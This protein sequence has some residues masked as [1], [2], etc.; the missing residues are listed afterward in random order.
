MVL[1]TSLARALAGLYWYYVYTPKEVDIAKLA[2]HVDSL[3]AQNQ[4]AKAELAKGSIEQIREEVRILRGNLDL[5]RTLVPTANEVPSL[6][7][8]VSSA[9]RRAHLDVG[10]IDPSPVIEGELF[11]TYR[12]RMPMNGAY[13]D[14]AQMLTNI[15]SLNRIVTA[16]NLQLVMPAGNLVSPP[17]KQLLGMT[18]DIQAY[19]IR[20]VARAKPPAPPGAPSDGK[21]PA[22]KAPG[23]GE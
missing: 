16:Y 6:I 2:T 11:D 22:G 5:M 18:F 14:I 19:V 4:R 20:T 15:G 8:Q 12:Y 7:D 23:G 13:H 3:D 17:G 10:T 1:I 21:A 9:A